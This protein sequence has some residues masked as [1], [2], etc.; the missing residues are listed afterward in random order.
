MRVRRNTGLRPVGAKHRVLSV[1]L[2]FALLAGIVPFNLLASTELCTMSCCAM[3]GPHTVASHCSGS[4][5]YLDASPSKEE[6]AAAKQEAKAEACHAEPRTAG[7]PPSAS[8][9]HK[10]EPLTVIDRHSSHHRSSG[11]ESAP[12]ER[13]QA[14]AGHSGAH[15]SRLPVGISA[16]AMAGGCP[17]SCGA[18][19]AYSFNQH[20]QSEPAMSTA[21][22]P[23]KNSQAHLPFSPALLSGLLRHQFPPRAPPSILS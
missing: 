19:T 1:T 14:G 23:P 15:H 20:R 17:R 7:P 21:L 2:V 9:A 8:Q 13:L 11:P 3:R 18:V 5:C 4:V 6:I 16:A 22:T 10:A 12:T